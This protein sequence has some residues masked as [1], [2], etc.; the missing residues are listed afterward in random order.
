MT[1]ILVI[2]SEGQLGNEIQKLSKDIQEASFVFTSLET[3]DVTDS[4]K[5]DETVRN[6][7]YDYII[8]CTAYTAV[9]KAEEDQNLAYE[10][11]AQALE[12]IGLA[13]KAINA[14]VIHVS[15]DYVFDGCNHKPYIESDTTAP[16]SVYGK[17]KL[18]GEQLLMEKNHNSIV[19]RT[20]WLYS[21]HGNN[22]VKTM[23]KLGQERDEL[24]IIFDQIGSPT[25]AGDLAKS[26]IH[27]VKSD[28]AQSIPFIAGIYHYSNEGVA[29]WYDFA[30]T[31]HKKKG[32]QCALKPIESKEYPT[33]APRPHYSVMNKG[34]IKKAYQLT[35]PHWEDSLEHCLA[36]LDI[37]QN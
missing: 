6:T 15:T 34:K 21:S 20:S 19:I 12:V 27:M 16:Q 14:K 22:F 37:K 30:R 28:I 17:T 10:I 3:L 23:I 4:N 18:K 11:N 24:G 35:I 8:N 1:Q 36:E 2:G 26:I 7:N 9:D 5:L 25:Y 29:S 31:I 33:P 32:I 13:S